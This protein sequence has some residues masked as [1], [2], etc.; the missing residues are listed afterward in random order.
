MLKVNNCC[1]DR[2]I[3]GIRGPLHSRDMADCVAEARWLA[4]EGEELIVVAQDPT[5]YGEDSGK[6]GSN[7]RAAG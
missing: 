3:P 2:A 5:A 6:P 7:R 4:G 1:H